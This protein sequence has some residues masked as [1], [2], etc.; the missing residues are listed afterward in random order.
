MNILRKESQ[1]TYFYPKASAFQVLFIHSVIESIVNV[2]YMSADSTPIRTVHEMQSL[3]NSEVICKQNTLKS[4][5]VLST[6]LFTSH[7]SSG[8]PAN[9]TLNPVFL[10]RFVFQKCFILIYKTENAFN[11]ILIAFMSAQI[12]PI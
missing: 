12:M 6:L 10:K 9:S 8:I 1:N 2:I 7:L 5:L 4:S 11:L 3:S